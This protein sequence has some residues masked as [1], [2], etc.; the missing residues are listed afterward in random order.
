MKQPKD[1][2]PDVHVALADGSRRYLS[3][4]WQSGPLILV[5]LRHLG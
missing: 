3:A 5:F 1:K 2:A 4:F